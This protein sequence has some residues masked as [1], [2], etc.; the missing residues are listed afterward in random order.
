MPS[1]LNDYPSI[2]QRR[3]ARRQRAAMA[4][5]ES[6]QLVDDMLRQYRALIIAE[7]KNRTITIHDRM[8][9]GSLKTRVYRWAEVGRYEFDF[10]PYVR[11]KR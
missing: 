8:H 2:T 9:F 1:T 4:V 3:E 10:V 5:R 6:T 7:V 11:R